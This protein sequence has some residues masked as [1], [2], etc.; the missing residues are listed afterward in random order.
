MFTQNVKSI[1]S[2][3]HGNNVLHQP[4]YPLGT[5]PGRLDRPPKKTPM[6]HKTLRM[7]RGTFNCYVVLIRGR[8]S[9]NVCL[10]SDKTGSTSSTVVL[11]VLLLLDDIAYIPDIVN[12]KGV[13]V[14]GKTR[15]IL[16]PRLLLC[17]DHPRCK[18]IPL[19]APGILPNVC[20]RSIPPT[21]SLRAIGVA[22]IQI[23]YILPFEDDHFRL[24]LQPKYRE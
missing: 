6:R 18:C 9:Q 17:K 3:P 2:L 24:T 22:V 10:R 11:V 15:N 23:A 16:H 4:Y 1:P 13:L 21:S 5:R 20:A 12:P 19:R 8:G 14:C 7:P